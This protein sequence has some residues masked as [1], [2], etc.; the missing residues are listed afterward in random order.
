MKLVNYFL[1]N[2]VKSIL[3]KRDTQSPAVFS[4]RRQ[5]SKILSQK[6]V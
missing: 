3:K 1:E 6:T 2:I 4:P 5:M